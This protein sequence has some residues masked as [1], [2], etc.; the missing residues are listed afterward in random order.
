[1]FR[2]NIKD[3]IDGNELFMIFLLLTLNIFIQDLV[4]RLRVFISNFEI[5]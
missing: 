5:H 1:M 2:F 4:H 3:T